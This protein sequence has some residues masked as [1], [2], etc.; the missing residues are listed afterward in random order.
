MSGSQGSG[1]SKPRK[2]ARQYDFRSG[3]SQVKVSIDQAE[4]SAYGLVTHS[5]ESSCA[6]SCPNCAPHHRL[7]ITGR[8]LY[9]MEV[10]NHTKIVRIRT[11]SP[12][13]P[14]LSTRNEIELKE[15]KR[16][17]GQ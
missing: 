10:L 2:I 8:C 12:L 16:A 5:R 14:C 9:L 4:P 13:R 11:P 17:G 6:L 15:K 7:P 1:S 3:V